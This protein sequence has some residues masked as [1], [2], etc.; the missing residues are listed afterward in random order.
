MTAIDIPFEPSRREEGPP[1]HPNRLQSRS[2]YPFSPHAPFHIPA[3][4]LHRLVDTGFLALVLLSA[5][6][7]SVLAPLPLFLL[8]LVMAAHLGFKLTAPSDAGENEDSPE[9]LDGSMGPSSTISR[10][11]ASAAA[12]PPACDR[13]KGGP[14]G[15][16]L[17]REAGK[18]DG[19]PVTQ[20]AANHLHADGQPRRGLADG[21]GGR[22]KVG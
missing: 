5:G 1:A 20:V 4:K 9:N 21:H 22:R 12:Q 3:L 10:S 14:P 8:G 2:A 6:C 18:S 16:S 17:S 19:R 15:R 13:L 7:F 11:S